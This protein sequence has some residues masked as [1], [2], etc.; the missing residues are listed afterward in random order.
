MFILFKTNIILYVYT[1]GFLHLWAIVK[2]TAMNM[3]V[4][5]YLSPFFQLSKYIHRNRIA[6][7]YGNSD[8][9]VCFLVFF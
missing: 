8:F 6:E 3:M 9:R 5:I 2:N 4:Q 1:L 7:S